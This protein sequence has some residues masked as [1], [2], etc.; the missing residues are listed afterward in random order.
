MTNMQ[1]DG[2]LIS[3]D[4]THQRKGSHRF[5]STYGHSC[6]MIADKKLESAKNT[7]VP[8]HQ[9]QWGAGRAPLY[10][11]AMPLTVYFKVDCSLPGSIGDDLRLRSYPFI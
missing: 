2:T 1:V 7:A 3:V 5:G 8:Q 9:P 11:A 10:S 4:E 6:L